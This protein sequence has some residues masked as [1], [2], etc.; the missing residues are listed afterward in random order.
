MCALLVASIM[1][2]AHHGT[3]Q[4]VVLALQVT[5]LAI[6]VAAILVVM[7]QMQRRAAG[8][9]SRLPHS[10]RDSSTAYGATHD[11]V[12]ERTRLRSANCA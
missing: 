2:Y 7:L 1:V 12:T 6:V 11:V 3:L 10:A 4:V 8:D 5:A 9:T